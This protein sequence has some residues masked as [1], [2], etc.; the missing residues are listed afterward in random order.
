[1]D[2][3]K[4]AVN[5]GLKDRKAQHSSLFHVLWKERINSDSKFDAITETGR[6]KRSDL[7]RKETSAG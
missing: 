7:T 3:L 5:E 6:E 4:P 1:M 2:S